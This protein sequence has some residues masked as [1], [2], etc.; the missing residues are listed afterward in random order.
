VMGT[1]GYMSPEQV[2]GEPATPASDQFSW[3]AFHE[4][5]TGNRP[6]TAKSSADVMSA[7]LRDDPPPIT[8]SNPSAPDPVCWIVERCLAKSA[9]HRYV[10][11]RDLAR[12]LQTLRGHVLESKPR[13]SIEALP[14]PR[15]RWWWRAAAAAGL[16]LAGA[17]VLLTRPW[18]S[19]P[20]ADFHRLTFRRGVVY[21]ALFVPKSGTILTPGRGRAGQRGPTWRARTTPATNARSSPRT[22]FRWPSRGMDPRSSLLGL[23]GRHQHAGHAGMASHARRQAPANPPERRL[24]R[25]DGGRPA[26][27]GRATQA[28]SACSRSADRTAPSSGPSSAPRA[29]SPTCAFPRRATA[30]RSSITR[31]VT[32]TGASAASFGR[33]GGLAGADPALE[34]CV[35]LA[36]NPG[37]GDIW[38]TGS[39]TGTTAVPCGG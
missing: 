25:L 37:T 38:F 23:A 30:S 12:D 3:A 27:R 5:L 7:I 22:S 31:R 20:E 28:R 15:R 39:R 16:L 26:A 4:V 33:T 36:W 11:T 14:P 19:R 35:R 1:V 9:S 17:A 24:G 10:S 6:F 29:A 21:R 13:M 18:A 8:E 32:T 34:R 2:R